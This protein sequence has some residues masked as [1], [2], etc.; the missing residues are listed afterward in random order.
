MPATTRR[1]VVP[2]I[3]TLP[4]QATSKALML[5]QALAN[6]ARMD[7]CDLWPTRRIRSFLQSQ[8][9]GVNQPIVNKEIGHGPLPQ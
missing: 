5:H 2:G 8:C 3:P 7:H 1:P 9:S 6:M 4:R